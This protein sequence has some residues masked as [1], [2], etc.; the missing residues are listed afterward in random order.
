MDKIENLENENEVKDISNNIRRMSINFRKSK[1]SDKETSV[2]PGNA[3]EQI[4]KLRNK[5]L[6][7]K[8]KYTQEVKRLKTEHLRAI[9]I[10]KKIHADQ[11]QRF[12]TLLTEADRVIESQ[13]CQLRAFEREN[14]DSPI[15]K[16]LSKSKPQNSIRRFSISP[17]P[18]LIVP[19]LVIPEPKSNVEVD[20]LQMIVEDL[21]GK[22]S[23]LKRQNKE[24]KVKLDK[25]ERM[26]GKS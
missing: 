21:S 22:V 7:Q 26:V 3:L 20:R 19:S 4:A 2:N 9:Q 16:L 6:I 23:I 12:T 25:S 15:I 13:E 24:Y 18:P 8:E 11:V 1:N 10:L 5:M 14:P 17:Q